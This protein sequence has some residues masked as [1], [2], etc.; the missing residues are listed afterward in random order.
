MGIVAQLGLGLVIVLCA[1]FPRS[2]QGHDGLHSRRAFLLDRGAEAKYLRHT[3]NFSDS[4]PGETRRVDPLDGLKHYRGGFDIENKHYWASVLFSGIYGYALAV[5]SVLLGLVFL[6]LLFVRSMKRRDLKFQ[7]MAPSASNS[8]HSIV[9]SAA[10]MLLTLLALVFCC[11]LLVGNKRL[12]EDANVVK[13]VLIEAANNATATIYNVTTEMTD[14][15]TKLEPFDGNLTTLFSSK[16]RLYFEAVQI[17]QKVQDNKK[18]IERTLKEIYIT[19]LVTSSV[20]M[21]F[22]IVGL[23]ILIEKTHPFWWWFFPLIT[24]ALWLLTV[25]SWIA[26]GLSY[27]AHNVVDD[28]CTA[29]EEYQQNP[30]NNTNALGLLLPCVDSKNGNDSVLKI[31]EGMYRVI[32]QANRNISKLRTTMDGIGDNRVIPHICNPFSGPPHYKLTGQCLEGTVAIGNV[33]Q[34]LQ[35]FRCSAKDEHECATAEGVQ[36]IP[37][38]IYRT[39]LAYS[40][41][42]QTLIDATPSLESLANCSFVVRA[43]SVIVDG[44][45]RPV[46]S[47]IHLLWA[48]YAGLATT[49]F[50][51]LILYAIRIYSK[52]KQSKTQG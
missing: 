17:Q 51:L 14:I 12:H 18:M 34:V 6:V 22:L 4:L 11:L 13:D 50:L 23:V 38:P 36:H 49:A 16:A 52:L 47:S 30:Y 44:K 32:A 46:R 33:P 24:V 2:L 21:L 1:C 15:T 10:L 3:R 19:I 25:F 35:P 40:A 45:C 41:A 39:I 29:L 43:F 5:A 8:H 9:S 37:D 42:A 26:F 27:A 48:A 20:I 28:S 7:K 31:R